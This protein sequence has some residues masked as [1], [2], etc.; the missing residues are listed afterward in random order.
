M[1]VIYKRLLQLGCIFISLYVTA[2]SAAPNPASKDYV[3]S[4]LLGRAASGGVV[5]FTYL[6]GTVVHGLVAATADEPGLYTQ[7]AA[8]TRCA[9]KSEGG[10][11]DWFLPNSVQ[12]TALFN[13]RF[14]ISPNEANAGFA[15]TLPLLYWTSTVS[16]SNGLTMNF[17]NGTVVFLLPSSNLRVRCIRM[18]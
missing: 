7:A 14:A 4:T 15:T 5:F 1:N 10:Y 9:S 2:V 16:N 13:N 8:I 18:I 3:N 17:L 11:D 6:S 12:M